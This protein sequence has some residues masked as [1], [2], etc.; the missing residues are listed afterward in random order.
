MHLYSYLHMITMCWPPLSPLPQ[1]DSSF[2]VTFAERVLPEDA[3]M[4]V[5]ELKKWYSAGWAM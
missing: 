2:L 5:L 1:T 3:T 4:T